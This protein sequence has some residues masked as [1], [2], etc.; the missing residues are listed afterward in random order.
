MFSRVSILSY[1]ILFYRIVSILVSLPILTYP[2]LSYFQPITYPI[3]KE[4]APGSRTLKSGR[5][6]EISILVASPKMFTMI[7]IGIEGRTHFSNFCL[8]IQP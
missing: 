8:C 2:V 1:P 3:T 5:T 7:K 4:N 6:C